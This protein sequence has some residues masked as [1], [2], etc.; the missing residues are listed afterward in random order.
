MIWE[1]F[2]ARKRPAP[3]AGAT[4]VK[5]GE[6]GTNGHIELVNV[7]LANELT[8]REAAQR[9]LDFRLKHQVAVKATS[10][11]GEMFSSDKYECHVRHL[12]EAGST[13]G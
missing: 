4:W 6:V 3:L 2:Y 7:E 9:L 12:A 13:G 8:R 11:A 5:F 1:L 10:P